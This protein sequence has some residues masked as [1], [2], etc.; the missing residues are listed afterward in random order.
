MRLRRFQTRTFR[1]LVPAVVETDAALVAFAGANGQGKTNLLEAIGLLGTLKSF[2]TGRTA[3]VVQTGEGSAGVEALVDSEGCTRRF[4]WGWTSEGRALHR[5]D[6]VVDAVSWLRSLRA[7]W[8]A[9]A[10]VGLIR[11]EPA[12][13]RALLD[14]A[15]LTLDP[16]YLSVARD[17]HRILDHKAALLRSNGSDAEL[18]AVDARFL[19]LALEVGRRRANA[20]E[21]LEAP[22]LANHA[23]FA[24]AE[25][26][27]FRYRRWAGE[28]RGAAV[29]AERREEERRAGRVLVGPHREDLVFAVDGLDARRHA[30]QGQARSLVLAWKLAEVEAAS[31][32]G[33]APLFLLDDLGSELDGERTERLVTRLLTLGAQVF[34]STTDRRTL[35]VAD[36]LVY[37][38]E[39][40]VATAWG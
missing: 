22:F 27:S 18:D 9:P 36:A 16:A 6:R 29:L 39:A 4:S 28:A 34:V 19:V 15:V 21:R 26:A 3:D 8:F 10:D 30:S 2:R 20:L 11:G 35:P 38:V 1:N 17:F 24:G 32:E 25:V 23:S 40:G 33:D 13:R 7:T 31:G 14:R 37:R 12:L 5:E